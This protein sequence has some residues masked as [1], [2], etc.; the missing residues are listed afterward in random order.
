MAA[1]RQP[2][3]RLQAGIQ[4]VWGVVLYVQLQAVAS[5]SSSS[6]SG[7]GLLRGRLP[8]QQLQPLL[9]AAAAAACHQRL[10]LLGQLLAGAG[11]GQQSSLLAALQQPLR[12]QCSLAL[13][14]SLWQQLGSEGDVQRLLLLQGMVVVLRLAQDGL[15]CG[16][17]H[18]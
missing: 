12:H 2:V 4:P 11:R 3:L 17:N 1:G 9:L 6:S 13:Q 10:L 14:L 16:H 15:C 7:S 8:R 18:N 5:T